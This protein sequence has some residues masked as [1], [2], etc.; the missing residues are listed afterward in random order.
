MAHLDGILHGIFIVQKQRRLCISS[1]GVPCET[2]SSFFCWLLMV[3]VCMSI[4]G[5]GAARGI[6]WIKRSAMQIILTCLCRLPISSVCLL[7]LHVHHRPKSSAG[8]PQAGGCTRYNVFTP[9]MQVL[10][11]L[12]AHVIYLHAMR[13]LRSSGVCPQ[14][15]RRLRK[16]C[17]FTLTRAW[18]QYYCTAQRGRRQRRCG[19]AASSKA[20]SAAALNV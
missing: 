11:L 4:A 2:I 3:F 18:R 9:F 20:G 1:R 15:R 6:H 14:V 17:A 8:C 5:A 12:L 7:N 10:H 19:P 13:R 16:G